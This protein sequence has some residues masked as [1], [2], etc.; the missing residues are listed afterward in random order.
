MK[1]KTSLFLLST[2]FVI[3][4]AALGYVM[5]LTSELVNREV[6]ESESATKIIKDVFELSIVTYEYLSHHEERMHQQW[7]LKYDSLGEL[8]RKRAL[9]VSR[10]TMIILHC[11]RSR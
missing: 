11:P 9:P 8:L 3:L 5:F 6:R 4:I 7:L 1:I 10:H 2:I